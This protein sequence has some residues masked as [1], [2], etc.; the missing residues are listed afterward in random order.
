MK[1]SHVLYKTNN[2]EECVVKFKNKGFE[3]EFG[4]KT[5]PHNALIYFSE[6]PYIEL[7]KKAPVP[8]YINLLLKVVGKGKVADDITIKTIEKLISKHQIKDVNFILS[9]DNSFILQTLIGNLNL[10]AKGLKKHS[11]D[12][13]RKKRHLEVILKEENNGYLLLSYILN[14]K[15]KELKLRLIDSHNNPIKI[16]AKIYDRNL[17]DFKNIYSELIFFEKYNMN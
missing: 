3:V 17:D 16:G 10:Q 12:I 5:N 1:V 2:L 14:N 7:L 8:F 11:E 4:S 6:G 13:K 9:L 15:I